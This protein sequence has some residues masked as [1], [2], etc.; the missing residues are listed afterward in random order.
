MKWLLCLVLAVL[1]DAAPPGK[2]RHAKNVHNA[3]LEKKIRQKEEHLPVAHREEDQAEDDAQVGC[4][5]R[6][7]CAPGTGKPGEANPAQP[8]GDASPD[9]Q[10]QHPELKGV[11]ADP[12]GAP[13]APAKAKNVLL[14]IVDDMRT[15]TNVSYGHPFMITP[16]IDKFAQKP[17][18]VTFTRAYAQA[19]HCA[20]SRNSFMSGR[21][22]DTTKIYNVFSD[23]RMRSNP[24]NPIIPIPQWFKQHG[25]LSFGGG[26][27]YHPNHPKMNDRPFSWSEGTVNRTVRYFDDH[28]HGCPNGGDPKQGGCYGCP[29]D[30]PDEEFYDGRLASWTIDA[31]RAAKEDQLHGEKKPFFIATGFRRPHTPWNVAQR[32]V[33]MYTDLDLPKH[34]EWA[35]GAPQCGFVCGGDGAG[36]DFSINKPRDPELTKICRRSYYASVTGTDHYIGQVLDELEDLNMAH[37]TAVALFGDHGW[38]LGEGGLWAKYTN[39]ELS[40]R[41]PLIIRAPWLAGHHESIVGEEVLRS[42]QFVELVDIYPT[43]VGLAGIPE[44]EGLDG[45][46]LVSVIKRPHEPKNHRDYAQS[47]FAHCCGWGPVDANRQCGACGMKATEDISYMGY[48]VRNRIYRLVVWYRWDNRAGLPQCNG[49]MAVELYNHSGDTGLGAA[50]FDDFEVLNVAANKSLGD[51][52]TPADELMAEMLRREMK[53][54]LNREDRH[55]GDRLRVRANMSA[56]YNWEY[57]KWKMNTDRPHVAAV[58]FMHHDLLQKFEGAFGRCQPAVAVQQ[59]R[60]RIPGHAARRAKKKQA[61]TSMEPASSYINEIDEDPGEHPEWPELTTCPNPE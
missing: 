53:S 58:K 46:S 34:P 50:S 2:G 47:Q 28:D 48:A 7:W 57:R 38:H 61:Q 56:D 21:Y 16:S 45:R 37:N 5:N 54:E 17:G 43:L 51:V 20:P 60:Q 23:F 19:A 59:H 14:I 35:K 22:P 6:W 44:P 3:G 40:T 15:Q 31:L 30:K 18:A 9:S 41:V 11:P 27:I 12:P 26:K 8:G 55:F 10:Q 29:E 1:A 25:Y 13:K 4:A 49:L 39:T 52:L 42:N 24:A 32:F 36:C 33:D